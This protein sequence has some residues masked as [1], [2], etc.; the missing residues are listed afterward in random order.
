MIRPHLRIPFAS[1]RPRRL[2]NAPHKNRPLVPSSFRPPHN[3]HTPPRCATRFDI[4]NPALQYCKFTELATA[5][6]T[7]HFPAAVATV[8]I[9]LA[10]R[11]HFIADHPRPIKIRIVC[12]QKHPV[13]AGTARRATAAQ[14]LSR[15]TALT[16]R[17]V[18]ISHASYLSSPAYAG[19]YAHNPHRAAARPPAHRIQR[20][21]SLRL[22]SASGC[23]HKI[24]F[25]PAPP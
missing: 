3:T 23:S 15:P 1:R 11:A 21:Y 5:S 8:E 19:S 12:V 2:L 4:S 14:S 10:P 17:W 13:H 18:P 7:R 16:L 22:V 24:S 25:P 20:A 6:H 9:R